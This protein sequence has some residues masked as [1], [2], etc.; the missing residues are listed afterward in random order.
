MRWLVLWLFAVALI[1]AGTG[2]IITGAQFEILVDGTPRSYPDCEDIAIASAEFLKSRTKD[3]PGP[4]GYAHPGGPSRFSIPAGAGQRSG[5][6]NEMHC[7]GL[8]CRPR[9]TR[10]RDGSQ[11]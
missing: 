9:N 2:A 5:G 8:S 6:W 4:V 7:S 11:Q 3:R 1:Y 10:D